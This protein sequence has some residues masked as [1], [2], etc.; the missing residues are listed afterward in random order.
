MDWSVDQAMFVWLVFDYLFDLVSSLLY[1]PFLHT[2]LYGFVPV[3]L[4]ILEYRFTGLTY[5]VRHGEN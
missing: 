4:F 3:I 5:A 1:F 2:S